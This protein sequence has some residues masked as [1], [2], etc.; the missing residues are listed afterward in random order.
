[1]QSKLRLLLRRTAAPLFVLAALTHATPAHAVT[2]EDRAA[3]RELAMQGLQL[4]AAA[5]YTEALDRFDRAQAVFPAPTHLI[6][7]A[8]CLAALGKLVEASEQY[9]LL[10]RTELPA[11]APNAF[12][13]AQKQGEGELA[14]L[15]PRIPAIRVIVRPSV[16][17]NT[18]VRI[19]DTSISAALI[20]VARPTNPGKHTVTLF[21]PGYAQAEQ[22]VTLEEHQTRDVAFNLGAAGGYAA[23]PPSAPTPMYQPG[24]SQQG[25]YPQEGYPPM[26]PPP[27]ENHEARGGFMLGANLGILIPAGNAFQSVTMGSLVGGGAAVGVDAGFRFVKRLYLG[28]TFEHGF[29]STGNTLTGSGSPGGSASADSNY[30]GLD[31]AVITNPDGAAFYAKIG[32]GYRYVD[33]SVTNSTPTYSATLQ[34]AELSL[35]AGVALKLGQW[36]RL[37]PEASV[38]VGT[39]GSMNCS[40]DA[41]TWNGQTV[42][43]GTITSGDTHEFVLLGAKFFIDFARKH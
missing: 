22:S 36:I 32:G 4:Q 21:A 14:Q 23:M 10:V 35:S 38:N 18:T 37:V 31:F 33:L 42:N 1:M 12:V 2:D 5:N 9:R 20:G 29:L 26:A 27:A 39:F 28:L 16:P 40:G 13:Q 43:C 34:G 11:N 24:T 17:M 19:D 3:A 7:I 8:Q 30:I 6:H 25:Y 41:I 15:E